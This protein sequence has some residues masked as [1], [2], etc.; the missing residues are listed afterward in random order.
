[1]SSEEASSIDALIAQGHTRVQAIKLYYKQ[2]NL[3]RSQ[4]FR[5][6]SNLQPNV[7][8]T[9][10]NMKKAPSRFNNHCL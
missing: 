1:M 9:V 7:S 4:S 6:E 3:N 2:N 5:V 8:P 10:Q